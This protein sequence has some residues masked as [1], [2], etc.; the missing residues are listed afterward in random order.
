MLS[1]AVAVKLMVPVTV[2]LAAGPVTA[3]VGAVVSAATV[4]ATPAEVVKLPAASRAIAVTVWLLPAARDVVLY[5]TWYGAVVSSFP[6]WVPSRRNL[7]PATPTLSAAVAAR[8]IV[9][10]TA[11]SAAGDVTETVG[12]VGSPPTTVNETGADVVV[13]PP[14]SRATAVSVCAP[15]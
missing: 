11:A 13:S 15:G 12:A 4:N 10:V 8:V 6:T 1:A 5:E 2:A 14:A 7:T 9:P 3:T